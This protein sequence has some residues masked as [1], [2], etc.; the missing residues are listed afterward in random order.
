MRIHL[1]ATRYWPAVGGVENLL[2]S[3]A[4]GL[5]TRH[6]VRVSAIHI[7]N[8]DGGR[9]GD[10]L[11]APPPFE[12]F[13]DGGVEVSPLRPLERHRRRMWPLAIEDVRGIRRFAY[14]RM[15]R[16]LGATFGFAF[17]PAI[18]D[19]MRD[20]DLIHVW[21]GDLLA[22]AARDAAR[23]LG[24]PLIV[25][26]FVH[27]GQWADDAAS[28]SV[29]CAADRTIALLET[30]AQVHARLGVPRDRICVIGSCSP[31]VAAANGDRLRARYGIGA[32]PVV[33]FLG[34]KRPYKGADLLVQATPRLR[35]RLPH[36]AVVLAGPGPSYSGDGLIDVGEVSEGDRAEWLA[37]ADIV[38]LPSAAEIFPIS[39]LEAWSAA[40]PVLTSD[41]P[42]LVELSER[43]GGGAT[44]PRDPDKL[45]QSLA[46]L[47]ADRA[48]LDAMGQAGLRFWR[49][50]FTV[51][52]VVREHERV[53][54]S[55][56]AGRSQSIA[57]G[58]PAS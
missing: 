4:T 6:E 11:L 46:A 5:A 19:A 36:A 25:S 45:A 57:V 23:R 53:Y 21:N 42:P 22:A 47:L 49:E 7:D 37:A 29:Y 3:V 31:G 2:R 27:P 10:S 32:D 20:A 17:S 40:T 54:E 34:V 43:S 35:E 48:R 39:I 26:P 14:G 56:L 28:A 50:H 41:I 38:C 8:H 12:A 33:L 51:D 18:V 58:G 16:L 44:V 30:D 15:R 13:T 55:T 24:V 1:V 9:L 52:A